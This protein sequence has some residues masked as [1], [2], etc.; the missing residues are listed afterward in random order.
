MNDSNVLL[1]EDQ[2]Q[3]M[4]IYQGCAVLAFK[5]LNGEE[6][7]GRRVRKRGPGIYVLGCDLRRPKVVENYILENICP[8]DAAS[9]VASYCHPRVLL[10]MGRFHSRNIFQFI[11]VWRFNI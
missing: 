6:L 5:T 3:T 8:A 2:Y 7:L 4:I 9:V 10:Y 1:T 11:H